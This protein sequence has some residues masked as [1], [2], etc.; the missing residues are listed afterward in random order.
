MPS[1]TVRQLGN[2]ITIHRSEDGPGIDWIDVTDE[3]NLY[4]AAFRVEDGVLVETVDFGADH[5]DPEEVGPSVPYWQHAGEVEPD[6]AAD[7]PL[8]RMLEEFFRMS[9]QL[10]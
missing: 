6:R 7:P 2:I 4:R 9:G 3:T 1:T 5:D 8:C 10:Q